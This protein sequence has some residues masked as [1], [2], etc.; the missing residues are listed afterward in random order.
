M[1]AMVTKVKNEWSMMSG[2]CFFFLWSSTLNKISKGW[3]MDVG[4]VATTVLGCDGP[5]AIA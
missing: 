3:T 4:L 2:R 1:M 5:L